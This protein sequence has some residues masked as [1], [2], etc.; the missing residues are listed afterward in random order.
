MGFEELL[1][2]Q[3][4]DKLFRRVCFLASERLPGNC[5]VKTTNHIFFFQVC[6]FVSREILTS[7]KSLP[8]D[9][10]QSCSSLPSVALC[11]WSAFLSSQFIPAGLSLRRYSTNASSWVNLLAWMHKARHLPRPQPLWHSRNAQ[12]SPTRDAARVQGSS[13]R[14]TTAG[15]TAALCPPE[16]IQ[17][18]Q[19]LTSCS[20]THD[21]SVGLPEA[22]SHSN[23][24]CILQEQHCFVPMEGAPEF[25]DSGQIEHP[26]TMSSSL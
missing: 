24:S 12:H 25:A 2:S 14:T 23:V 7:H 21:G 16:A 15:D 10:Q 13:N 17:P 26:F 1:L 4:L 22:G 20:E 18:A 5:G 11:L 3:F 8:Y 19:L 6:I 9:R